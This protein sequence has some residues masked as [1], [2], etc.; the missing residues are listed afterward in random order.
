MDFAH[1]LV[2]YYKGEWLE[3]VLL[4]AYGIAT[5]SVA[6]VLWQHADQNALLKELFYPQ[7]CAA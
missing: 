1:D 7:R 3:A 5:T 6:V 2:S 4:T